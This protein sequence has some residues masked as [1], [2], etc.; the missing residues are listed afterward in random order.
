[1]FQDPGQGGNGQ[2]QQQQTPAGG[3][4]RD[5]AAVKKF[6]EQGGRT[7]DENGQQ[8]NQSQHPNQGERPAWLPEKFKTPEDLAKAY[9]ELERSQSQQQQPPKKK[10]DENPSTKPGDQKPAAGEGIDF[11]VMAQEIVQSGDISP[12]SRSLLLKAGIPDAMIQSHV[13]NLKS[14]ASSLQSTIHEAA[15]GKEAFEAMRTWAT[16]GGLTEAERTFLGVQ[17]AKGPEQAKIAVAQLRARFEAVNGKLPTLVGGQPG[18]GTIGF[19]STAEMV[20]A[21]KDPRY[22]K[23]PAYRADVEKRIEHASF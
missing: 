7:L 18:S 15:G 6:E 9:G 19:R 3:D 5:A 16:G 11:D 1:M 2:Q 8:Q 13:D 23:D 14:Q 10:D 21:M 4:S 12:Q 20:A 17:A 22:E